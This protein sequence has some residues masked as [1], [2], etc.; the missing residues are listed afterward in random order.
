[1]PK[2]F[3]QNV[4]GS[5]DRFT[6]AEDMRS[7]PC[8]RQSGSNGMMFVCAFFGFALAIA[9]YL[10]RHDKATWIFLLSFCLLNFYVAFDMYATNYENAF[11]LAPNDGQ[12]EPNYRR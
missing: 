11:K 1:M 10:N 3:K 4:H 7:L 9:T 12:I 8:E 6:N 5:K 2:L